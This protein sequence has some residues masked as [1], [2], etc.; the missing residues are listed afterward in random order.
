MSEFLSEYGILVL[1]LI[2][3]IGIAVIRIFNLNPQKRFY[4]DDEKMFEENEKYFAKQKAKKNAR[5]R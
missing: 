1:P 2:A 5:T 4:M 3:F